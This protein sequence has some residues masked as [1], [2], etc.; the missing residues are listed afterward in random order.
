MDASRPEVVELEGSHHPV[1][2]AGEGEIFGVVGDDRLHRLDP[3]GLDDSGSRHERAAGDS[4]RGG[5]EL[6]NERARVLRCWLL[7]FFL[8]VLGYFIRHGGPPSVLARPSFDG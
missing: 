1:V 5:D 6:A 8:L 4:Q 2:A 3:A 7:F